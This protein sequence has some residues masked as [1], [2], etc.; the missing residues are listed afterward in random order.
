V[1]LIS[2]ASL[3][4]TDSV[5]IAGADRAITF[6]DGSNLTNQY[7]L[8]ETRSS[9]VKLARMTLR[10]FR[11]SN[12]NLGASAFFQG[13]GSV[14]MS[15]MALRDNSNAISSST[16]TITIDDTIITN[17]SNTF[18]GAVG[19]NGSKATIRR[20]IISDNTAGY[21]AGIMINPVPPPLQQ[22]DLVISESLVS[23]NRSTDGTGGG[24]LNNAILTVTDSTISGNA[25][26][27]YGG[28]INTVG[29]S[30]TILNSTIVDNQAQVGGGLWGQY[31]VVTLRNTIVANNP[32]G[33][34]CVSSGLV[35]SL[36]NNL[37]SDGSCG[38]HAAQGDLS[39]VDPKLGPLQDNGGP[40]WTYGL[41][42]RSPAI[43]RADNATCGTVDQ[44]GL[45]RPKDGN[46]D[47]QIVCDIGAFEVQTPYPAPPGPCSP[48]PRMMIQTSRATGGRLQVTVIAGSGTLSQIQFGTGARTILNAA[49][50]MPGIPTRITTSQTVP[51]ASHPMQLTFFVSRL[52][53]GPT[54]LPMIVSDDCGP[55]ETFVGGGSAAF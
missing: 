42:E 45:P 40:T 16:G 22:S 33:G 47:N 15:Q 3:I 19:I 8:I 36:G 29:G 2:G 17:N 24:I 34:D 38:L 12:P 43:D 6:I 1:Y 14:T 48:R 30:T 39:N 23:N 26:S 32:H 35:T 31:G 50:D 55:W 20:S 13:A 5:E 28:G 11:I 46:S 7:S 37:D 4:I 54:T 27:L 53:A 41:L 52:A 21:G 9:T 10:G 49:V 18:G 25:A 51:L 44:R